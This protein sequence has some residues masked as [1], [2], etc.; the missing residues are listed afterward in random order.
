VPQSG[1]LSR[2]QIRQKQNFVGIFNEEKIVVTGAGAVLGQGIIKSL[3]AADMPCEI[4]AVDP[5]PLAVGL[6]WGDHKKIIPM[7]DDPSFAHSI[8]SMLEEYRPDALLVGTDAE[9]ATIAENREAWERSYGT[10][11]LVSDSNVVEIADDKLATVQFLIENRLQH[12]RTA[13]ADD[14]FAVEE[15]V[16]ECGFP[17]IVKPRRGARS[18][19]VSKVTDMQML[20]DK[21]AAPFG[22]I[23][24]EFAGEDDQEFTA[25]VLYFD[26]AVRTSIVLR[27]DLRDGN[28][29]RAYSGDY[30]EAEQYVIAVYLVCGQLVFVPRCQNTGQNCV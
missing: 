12:P 29:Y 20:R 26:N 13:L 30:P 10:K 4:L 9:L 15:L 3:R 18:I 11:V 28:T 8:G 6:H 23:V 5:S 16:A 24:Q 7:A 2:Y 17:L 22:L 19:G 27:R 14:K 21:T 25:G 1:K